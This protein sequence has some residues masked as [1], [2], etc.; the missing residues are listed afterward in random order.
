MSYI[1][2]NNDFHFSNNSLFKPY[3]IVSE[4]DT[5]LNLTENVQKENKSDDSKTEDSS[6][7][8]E[9]KCIDILNTKEFIQIQGTLEIIPSKELLKPKLRFFSSSCC[10]ID[11]DFSIDNKC[12]NGCTCNESFCKHIRCNCHSHCKNIRC[13]CFQNGQ[14][15]NKFCDCNKTKYGPCYNPVDNSKKKKVFFLVLFRI[16]IELC[17]DVENMKRIVLKVI[18]H[19]TKM[20]LY[21]E[22]TVFV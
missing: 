20:V 12:E 5:N 2:N 11:L 9:R 22:S 6:D 13:R 19:V 16:T 17:V 7:I 21:V 8:N 15:C 1:R 10:P 14:S 3:H 18:V 4:L